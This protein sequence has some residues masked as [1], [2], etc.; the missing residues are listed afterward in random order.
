MQ[1]GI[2]FIAPF[3]D[4]LLLILL[5]ITVLNL[6]LLLILLSRTGRLNKRYR[7]FM[8]GMTGKNLE[9]MLLEDIRLVKAA[10]HRA[11]E[12][13]MICRRLEGMTKQCL[14]GVGVVRYNAFQDV[15]S[16]L[17]FAVALL[18]RQGDG[19]VL[20]SLYGREDTRSY[21]KP[22]KNGQSTYPLTEEEK[23]A[24]RKALESQG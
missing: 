6:F 13:E 12:V 23:T 8:S 14:Q 19:V 15:G 18:D 5:A 3:R 4:P 17:S 16:D 7:Q 11:D 20:S 22:V 10:V 1:L 24:I 9:E 2:S 21:A